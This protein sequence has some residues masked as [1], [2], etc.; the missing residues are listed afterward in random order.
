MKAEDSENTTRI[1]ARRAFVGHVRRALHHLYDPIE[2]R[3]SPLLLLL[4][5]DPSTGISQLRQIMEAAIESL[6]PTATVSNQAD[7]WRTYRT[8]F[9]R[10][11]EQFSQASVSANLGLSVRQLR[12]QER[13]ALQTLADWL[14]EHYNLDLNSPLL[15]AS[16]V[17]DSDSDLPDGSE[18]TSDRHD[19]VEDRAGI[20]QELRWIE[21]SFPSGQVAISA[22]IASVLQTVKPLL[23]ASAV[24]CNCDLPAGLPHLKAQ[25][26]T[27]RQV[28]LN[29][30]TAAIRTVPGGTANISAGHSPP[31]V[32]VNI[33]PHA[34]ATTSIDLRATLT[35]ENLDIARELA[36][37]CGGSLEIEPAASGT[38]FSVRLLL[39]AVEQM[40]VLVI[41]DNADALQLTERY[42]SNSPYQ[43]VGARDPAQMQTLVDQY[44]P[45]AILLDVMLP[46]ID[47]WDLLGRLRE[48]PR[49]S[50][51]PVIICTIL[52]Q[53]ELA[54]QL[55]A[56]AFLRKPV[57]RDRLLRM[58][59]QQISPMGTQPT[60]TTPC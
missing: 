31:Y 8:L 12:R 2:L 57:T 45:R 52:P 27:V 39:P 38:P 26:V 22:A 29:I 6:K 4:N 14:I 36:N 34:A 33:Q 16:D 55:G 28:L 56:A 44:Q 3:K 30:L 53:E 5:L 13:L 58:L 9:H 10:F 17:S 32:W 23:I 59:D 46:N 50:N 42:L 49:T 19:D 25:S 20:E 7:A 54:L 51:I 41:D 47:G 24:S 37:L 15:A 11:I 18:D 60:A 21:Q 40:P 43:F 48:N 35:S 1:A